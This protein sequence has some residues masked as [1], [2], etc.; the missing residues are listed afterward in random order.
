MMFDLVT[1][2]S[3]GRMNYVFDLHSTINHGCFFPSEDTRFTLFAMSYAV[4]HLIFPSF[5]W[6]EK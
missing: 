6:G 5:F 3:F 4:M 1:I 2:F